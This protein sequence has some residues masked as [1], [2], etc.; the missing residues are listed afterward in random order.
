VVWQDRV[1]GSTWG[2]P[3]S[4]EGEMV[5]ETLQVDEDTI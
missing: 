3:L 2:F 5:E 4:E 1:L